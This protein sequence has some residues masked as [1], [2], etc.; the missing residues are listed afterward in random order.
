M[1]LLKTLKFVLIQMVKIALSVCRDL[2]NAKYVKHVGVERLSLDCCF[3][4]VF[5]FFFQFRV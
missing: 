1:F 2:C 3:V 5:F 4:L